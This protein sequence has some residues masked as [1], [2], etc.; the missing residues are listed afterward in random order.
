MGDN[1]MHRVPTAGGNPFGMRYVSD[2]GVTPDEMNC[3]P[4]VGT[5]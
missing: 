3:Y 2:T 4:P 1:A 5:R